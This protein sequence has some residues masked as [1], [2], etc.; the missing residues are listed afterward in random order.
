MASR[1]ENQRRAQAERLARE[2][3][4]RRQ[5]TLIATVAV[6]VVLVLAVVIGVV[7]QDRRGAEAL[8]DVAAPG[9][10]SGGAVVRGGGPVAVDIYEDFQCP[11]CK[12][13]EQSA[14]DTLTQL[15]TDGKITVRYHPI[16]FLDDASTT[17][18]SSR[19]LNAAAC[20][21]DEHPEGFD[22]LHK[23][24]F[25]Q[26]PDEG[27]AGLSDA[28]LTQLVAQA[29]A[30]N[31]AAC[32]STRQFASWVRAVTDQSSKDHVVQ[33]PTVRVDGKDLGTPTV[34]ALTSAVTAAAG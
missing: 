9:G 24:L 21:L 34:A 4:A 17:D 8:G 20:L 11:F 15:R 2:A 28:T 27:S 5:R 13:F 10:V 3:A 19:A 1:R 22:T 25:D 12:Q 29:G 30:P 6:V 18:Y 26:Q 7:V 14:G 31:A 33:T 32:I 16:A 23:A